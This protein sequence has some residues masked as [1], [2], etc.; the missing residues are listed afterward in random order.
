M[1]Q[2]HLT[3]KIQFCNHSNRK[4]ISNNHSLQILQTLLNMLRNQASPPL[5]LI[6]FLLNLAFVFFCVQTLC[7]AET[8]VDYF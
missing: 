8:G 5:L 6:D 3:L 1:L 4:L 7:L 2:L